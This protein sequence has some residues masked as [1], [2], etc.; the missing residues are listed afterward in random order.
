MGG[1]GGAGGVTSTVITLLLLPA[2]VSIVCPETGSF[3]RL[4]NRPIEIGPGEYDVEILSSPFQTKKGVK[5]TAGEETSIGILIQSP[6]PQA[7]ATKAAAPA[8]KK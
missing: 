1:C 7:A 8:K 6:V 2:T 3:T 5:I 4:T